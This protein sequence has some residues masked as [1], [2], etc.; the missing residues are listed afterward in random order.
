[1]QWIINLAAHIHQVLNLG[2]II[3]GCDE[4]VVCIL[5]L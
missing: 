1:M 4:S 5:I 2:N 3:A